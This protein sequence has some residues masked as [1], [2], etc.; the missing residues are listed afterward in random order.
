[1]LTKKL[2]CP[3]CDVIL[4]IAGNVAPGKRIKCPRCGTGFSVPEDEDED[5]RPRS[6]KAATARP[7]K[8]P[9][10]PREEEDADEE[11]DERPARRKS[12][13]K[14]KQQASKTPLV[15]G[16]VL[17]LV[18]LLGGGVVLAVVL[19]PR[20]Q[21]D[22]SA[23]KTQPTTPST[24]LTPIG[25]G[26]TGPDAGAGGSGATDTSGPFAAGRKVFEA[27][28]CARCH[29]MGGGRGKAPDLARV[30][31]DPNH[32]VDW[33]E[34]HIRNPKAHN[35]GSRMPGYEGRIQPQDLRALAEYLA[36]LK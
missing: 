18:L 8:A 14:R 32:T 30:G 28:G 5:E 34:Q 4:K 3:S 17:G 11:R 6:P 19:W 25:P 22:S 2:G 29:P 16:L 20:K 23:G 24:P 27:N 35:P 33:L 36:S 10:P 31:A 21:A 1:M 12:R 15:V 9:P 7:R 13:K 26:P